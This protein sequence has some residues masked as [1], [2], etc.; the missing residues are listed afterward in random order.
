M[1]KVF[2]SVN[3]ILI[4]NFMATAC[5]KVDDAYDPSKASDESQG[6]S[7]SNSPEQ[8][9]SLSIVS[10]DR[11]L[12]NMSSVAG[13]TPSPDTEAV[14]E[15]NKS[16]FPL[17]G[18]I[19]EITSGMWMAL[20]ALASSVCM[21]LYDKEKSLSDSNRIFYRGVN[22]SGGGFSV[23]RRESIIQRLTLA[24]WGR[25]ASSDEQQE[26]LNA[27]SEAGLSGSS[28]DESATR[29]VLLILCTGTLSALG[30]Q[31]F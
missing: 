10:S 25:S 3:I 13:V 8:E 20:T 15:R 26:L 11:V 22:F 1:K 7:I 30:A 5:L 27:M 19:S 6:L 2:T 16:A 17:N 29:D 9:T 14:M 18:E 12:R 31:T 4:L 23:E 24:F 21:D 28:L